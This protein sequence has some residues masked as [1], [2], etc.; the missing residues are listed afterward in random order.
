MFFYLETNIIW[1]THIKKNKYF[2]HFY[3]LYLKNDEYSNY[4]YIK[5]LT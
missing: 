5:I 4:A 1:H 3:I 2:D